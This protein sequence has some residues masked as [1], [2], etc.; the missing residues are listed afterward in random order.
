MEAIELLAKGEEP[1]IIPDE[2]VEKLISKLKNK[3]AKDMS[4]WKNEYI[5]S[6]GNEMLKSV[7][8]IM[9]HVDNTHEMPESWDLMKI[10]SIHK[11]GPKVKMKHKRGLFLT[12]LFSKIYERIVKARNQERTILS[13]FQTGGVTDRST[14]DNTM[15]FLAV[16]ERNLYLGKST[17]LTFADVEKCFDQM[18]LDDGIKDLWRSGMRA[19]DCIALKRLNETAN[20]VIETP[21]GQTSKIKLHNIVKQGTVYGP[22]ICAASMD[23]IN[24]IGYKTVTHYGPRVQI[25]TLAYVDDVGSA[26]NSNTANKTIQNC[27]LMEEEKKMTMNTDEG[28]SG[29]LIV[30]ERKGT[31]TVTAEVKRGE[32]KEVREY[33]YLGSWFDQSG[34]FKKNI[35]KRQ[36][37]LAYMI[38]STKCIANKWNMGNMSTRARL[39]LIETVLITSFLYNAEAY[40]TFTNEESRMLE[41]V[42]G[43]M[44]RDLLQVPMSTPYLPLLLESGMWTMEGRISYKK[45]MLFQNIMNSGDDRLIKNIVAEQKR[46]K[47][48]GTWYYSVTKLIEKYGIV[49]SHDELK[50]TWKRHVKERIATTTE[51]EIRWGCSK[52]SKGRTIVTDEFKVKDYL[53]AV[54]VNQASDILKVRLHMSALP[55]NYGVKNDCWLCSEDGVRTEHY[56][57]CPGTLLSR[58]CF[59]ILE[60]SL[61]T[62]DINELIKVSQFFKKLE[63]RCV[64]FKNNLKLNEECTM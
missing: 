52:M 47:R 15:V 22:A 40:P 13:P 25:Q 5:K 44:L 26:G 32:F 33:K 10:K 36:Q 9:N 29:V 27:S 63:E 46:T 24:E 56:L 41:G 14:I 53:S 7:K 57:R 16:I 37:K 3:K 39:K 50:S 19:R 60:I 12:N 48:P 8:I 61:G 51:E 28:K 30:K 55:C 11:K 4:R 20:V 1:E 62:Q 38:T 35:L 21:V 58:E 49:E 17:V 18:W 2:T 45:L 59:G 34:S 43:K 42:Q 23:R 31:G 54:N 6:G 64:L